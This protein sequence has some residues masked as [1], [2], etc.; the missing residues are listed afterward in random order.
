MF[1]HSQGTIRAGKV[2]ADCIYFLIFWLQQVESEVMH[3][4][5]NIKIYLCSST[6]PTE[7]N[8]AFPKPIN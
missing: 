2:C 7:Q 1:L 4:A 6:R 5:Y 8:Y 3:G